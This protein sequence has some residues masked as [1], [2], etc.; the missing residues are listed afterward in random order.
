MELAI[1]PRGIGAVTPNRDRALDRQGAFVVREVVIRDPVRR[2]RLDSRREGPHPTRMPALLPVAA[3]EEPPPSRRPEAGRRALDRVSLE[4]NTPSRTG[5]GM[6]CGVWLTIG[7]GALLGME[8]PAT[9]QASKRKEAPVKRLSFPFDA[10]TLTTTVF[11]LARA[12]LEDFQDPRTYILYGARLSTKAHWTSPQEVKSGKPKPWGYG[13]HLED[14]ALHCGHLLVALLEAYAA[15]PDPFLKREARRLFL[16]LK[17]IGSLSSVPGLVPRGPHPDDPRAFYDDSSMDQHTTFVISLARYAGS[18]LATAAEKT[19]IRE[20][21]QQVGD[22]LEKHDWSL[23]R[24]D[25]VTQAHVGFSWTEFNSAHASILLPTVLALYRGTGNAHWRK[26]YDRLGAEKH[27]ARWRALQ[28]GPHVRINAHPLYANQTAFRLNALY[29]FETDPQRRRRVFDLLESVTKLQLARDFPGPFYRRFHTDQEWKETSELLGWGDVDL[30]GC[31]EAWRKFDSS[32]LDRGIPLAQLAHVRFPLGGFHMVLLS[33]HRDLVARY[34]PDIW[35]MLTTVDLK[36]VGTGETNYLFTVVALHLYAFFFTQTAST[37]PADAGRELPIL[38]HLNLGPSMDVCV[39]GGHA[40][41]V[42]RGK[43]HVADVSQ[44]VRP[45]LVGELSGLGNV[46]QILVRDALAYVTAREDGLFIIDVEDPAAPKLLSH[47]DTIEFA[48]GVALSGNVLF[49][50]CRIYGVEI[51]DV[52]RPSHPAHLGI[53][54]TGEAQS[55]VARNGFL[56]AGVWG[57]SEVVA[58]DVHN[59]RHPQITARVPLDGY[60]DGVD[61]RAGRLYVATGHH[62]RLQPRGKEGDPGFGHGHGLEIFSLADPAKPTFLARIKMPPLY[63]MGMD[64]WSVTATDK[65]AF[66]ADTYNGVFVIDASDPE[67]PAVVARRRLPLVKAK[68]RPDPVGGLAVMKDL[69]YVAGAWS[70]LYVLDASGL[71]TP[72]TVEPDEAPSIPP[73]PESKGEDYRVYRPAGQVHAVAFLDDL[74]IVACGTAGLHVVQLWPAIQ[75][76]KKYPTLGPATDVRVLENR[77]YVA[78]SAGGMSLWRASAGGELKLEGRYQPQ[79]RPVKQVVVPPPGKYAMLQVGSTYLHIVDVSQPVEPKLALSDK[80]HGLLYRHQ[81]M[82]GLLDD[83][84]ACVFWHVSGLYWY[85][86]YGEATPRYTGDNYP[87]RIGSANGL[88]PFHGKTLVIC[89]GGYALIER[90]ERRSLHALRVYQTPGYRLVGKPALYGD[91]LYVSD[92]PS[93]RVAVVD[94][95]TLQSPKLLRALTTPGNPGRIA[96]HGGRGAFVIPD[97]YAGLLVFDEAP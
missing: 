83:R 2:G 39:E 4:P 77:I 44:P 72:P 75:A 5:K 23:T 67:N 87:Q 79:N 89:R 51:I 95:S 43:L 76:L 22:R 7:L 31:M 50:A 93:G 9:A 47:Y 94:V 74:A 19:W 69:V 55:V 10:T 32:F 37:M 63:E 57:T 29:H 12:Y 73:P 68:K 54:R 25:G 84:Y 53:A 80:H 52:T 92:R 58:V 70:G 14:T 13:S 90:N 88:V 85:D 60:G 81:I 11:S 48:T 41:I 24:A 36:R 49:V 40:Y 96:E 35:R 27:G 18:S 15:R 64:M 56:Y 46:R 28:A 82:D 42:G 6:L 3:A 1:T 21:L 61:V 65:Y 66:L 97:G 71:A 33:E 30:H 91:R 59:P 34:L 16:A 62:S 38:R 26:T 8:P 78:E 45:R 17:R 86:L 20:K